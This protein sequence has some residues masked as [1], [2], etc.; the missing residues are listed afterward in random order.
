MQENED[1]A[2]F[3]RELTKLGFEISK[4]PKLISCVLKAMA[5][6]GTTAILSSDYA[7]D[8]SLDKN[9]QIEMLDEAIGGYEDMMN[10]ISSEIDKEYCE[11]D[12]KPAEA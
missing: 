5:T 7:Q 10:S 6:V 4:Q 1:F 12:I 3:K 9:L 11:K 8:F 2:R